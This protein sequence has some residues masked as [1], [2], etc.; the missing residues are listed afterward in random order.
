MLEQRSITVAEN[1]SCSDLS[2]IRFTLDGFAWSK[3]LF[4]SKYLLYILLLYLAYIPLHFREHLL[5]NVL[6]QCCYPHCSWQV[7]MI[8]PSGWLI[9]SS[10][11]KRTQFIKNYRSVD[12]RCTPF[13][14]CL[15]QSLTKQLK[16]KQQTSLFYQNKN[17]WAVKYLK[18]LSQ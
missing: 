17:A 13:S 9:W 6:L 1:W 2:S 18:I 3:Q 10:H 14:I 5:W 7:T 15:S 16:T 4:P 8:L 12:E 11:D